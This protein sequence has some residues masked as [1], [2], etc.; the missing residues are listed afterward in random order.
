[1]RKEGKSR[2]PLT[3]LWIELANKD[4]RRIDQA[5]THGCKQQ[6][7]PVSDGERTKEQQNKCAHSG[8]GRV[9]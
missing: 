8:C 6:T 4:S 9:H 1:M 7:L 3:G 5:V 2:A